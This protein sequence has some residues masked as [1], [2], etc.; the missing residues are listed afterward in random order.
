MQEGSR[1]TSAGQ[2]AD[3]F[4]DIKR[5]PHTDL[6]VQVLSYGVPVAEGGAADLGAALQYGN[7]SSVAPYAG[8]VVA[9]IANNPRLGRAFVFPREAA[10]RTPGL[11][12]SPLGVTASPSQDQNY[13]TT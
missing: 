2:V 9:K 5:F 12:V 1:K 3:W 4:G 10:D 6:F 13:P 11:R 8:T 7:H